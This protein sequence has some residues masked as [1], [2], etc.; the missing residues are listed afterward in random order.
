MYFAFIGW[1]DHCGIAT[2]GTPMHS[3]SIV[4]FHPQCVTKHPTASC[5]ST[6]S[7]G[8]HV[9]MSPLPFTLFTKLSG[10][11][12]VSEFLTTHRKALPLLYSPSAISAI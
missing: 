1:S 10:I 12:E 11:F 4:E 9:T 6:C 7:C 2:I 5:A 3:P 8:L